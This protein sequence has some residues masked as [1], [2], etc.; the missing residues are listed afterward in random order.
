MSGTQT[1][2]AGRRAAIRRPI[3]P[4]IFLLVL[5]LVALAVWWKVLKKD[6][7]DA[8]AAPTPTCAVSTGTAVDAT[9][10]TVRVLNATEVPGLATAV[11]TE[12]A[13][14]GF[15]AAMPGNDDTGRD[16]QGTGELRY[17]PAGAE[18][19]L[20]VGANFP[21]LVL[22]LDAR[23][24]ATIDVA[25]GP[26]YSALTPADAVPAALAAAQASQSAASGGA[27]PSPGC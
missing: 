27:S 18:A 21:G 23:T 6:E 16:V 2:S 10:V 13:A 11:S 24:D 25:I 9:Q 15:I 14:R 17:G 4:L 1:T 8:D 5:A 19:A 22:V 7:A 20:V 26:A 12:L 3:P